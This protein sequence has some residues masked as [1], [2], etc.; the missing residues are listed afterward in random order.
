MPTERKVADN[1]FK[2]S[3]FLLRILYSKVLEICDII[4]DQYVIV[5]DKEINH[6]YITLNSAITKILDKRGF[7]ELREKQP[8]IPEDLISNMDDFD[9]DWKYDKEQADKFLE[10]IERVYSSSSS[11]VKLPK[12]WIEFL[13]DTDEAINNYKNNSKEIRNAFDKTL[14]QFGT[15]EQ[16][17]NAGK[18]INEFKLTIRDRRVM[19]NDYIISEPYAAGVNIEFIRYINKQKAY[20]KIIREDLPSW[21]K[22]NLG[23]KSFIK[24]LTDLGFKRE[25]RKL[26]FSEVSK[27]SFTFKGNKI[28]EKDLEDTNIRLDLLIKDL[29]YAHSRKTSNIDQS[30][31]E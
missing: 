21:L 31:S 20:D 6:H 9:I 4:A 16:N 30:R 18:K 12:K 11:T 8:I 5:K 24:I 7:E 22:D 26:F 15:H 27:D 1:D 23:K 3:I 17:L 28:S 14:D 29:D 13:K 19:V 25:I 2:Q 10:E